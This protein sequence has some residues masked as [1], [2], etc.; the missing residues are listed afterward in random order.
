MCGSICL[1]QW[2]IQV[3]REIRTYTNE[4][5][6]FNQYFCFRT[7]IYT[8]YYLCVSF[9]ENN[10]QDVWA[11]LICHKTNRK[12]VIQVTYVIE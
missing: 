7:L 5:Q 12:R 11:K 9:I 1:E 10:F 2:I 6:W 4:V 3:S 8:T